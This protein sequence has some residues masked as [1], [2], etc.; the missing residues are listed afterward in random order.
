M[1]QDEFGRT[2]EYMRV[3]V[4]DRCN[5]RC[6]Y[7]M[8]EE[9]IPLLTHD[10]ILRFGEIAAAVKVAVEE[11]VR[12]V[13]LT[14]GE[15]LVKRGIV[16]LIRE[17][18]VIAGLQDLALT[19]NGVLLASMASELRKA[20]LRRVNI[21]LPS[22]DTNAYAS[23]TRC[24]N[25]TGGKARE[26][27]EAAIEAGLS[28]VKVNV[29]M[30]RGTNDDPAPWL[31]LVRRLPVEVRFIEYMPIGPAEGSELFVS[32]AQMERRVRALAGDS[33]SEAPRQAG[34]GPVQKTWKIGDSPGSIGFIHAISEHFCSTC[35]RLRLTA[36]GH[37]RTCLFSDDELD[38][39]PALRPSIE[40]EKI[41]EILRAAVMAKPKCIPIDPR[42]GRRLM[43]QVGG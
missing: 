39:K 24:S 40:P 20:G 5:L 23:I 7:C 30:L 22:L 31:D 13:R 43:G 28:P 6:R 17:L 21:G 8:P 38:L 42:R 12:S 37:L 11:G 3:S 41:R 35:N 16:E 34:R 36:D 32:A 1:L 9:G 4:T 18:G 2:V 33:W 26:A 14:G 29:V 10:D 25:G 15:P 19:T 27:I